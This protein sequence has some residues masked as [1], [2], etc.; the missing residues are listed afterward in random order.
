MLELR[1]H[2]RKPALGL[3]ETKCCTDTICD[4]QS[5]TREGF[6]I[7]QRCWQSGERRAASRALK[8]ELRAK[9]KLRLTRSSCG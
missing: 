8:E 5:I 7:I 3:A 6:D 9:E 4:L 2:L 1:E